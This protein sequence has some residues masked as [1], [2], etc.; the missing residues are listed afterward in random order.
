MRNIM[1]TP[2][3]SAFFGLLLIGC[4]TG[5]ISGGGGDDDDGAAICGNG[6]IEATEG[7]DDGNAASG[8]GCSSTCVTEIAR[9]DVSVDLPS[10][11]T[12]LAS[13]TMLT[14]TVAGA[15]G[16]RGPVTLAATAVD[17]ASA[18]L[19]WT[20]ELSAQSINVAYD[21]A[22]VTVVARVVIPSDGL[23]GTGSVRVTATSTA[24]AGTSTATTTFVVDNRVTI[25]VPAVNGKC[26][27]PSSGAAAAT[28]VKV[29]TKL[30]WVNKGTG[31]II[32]HSNG[33][34]RGIPHQNN[35]ASPIDGVYEK[36]EQSNQGGAGDLITTSAGGA[37]SWYCHSGGDDLG[38]NNPFILVVQ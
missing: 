38:G 9:V 35:T 19:P 1:R 29:G 18:V 33:G 28:R 13:E 8:D 2:I 6:V 12:D 24:G 36:L 26:A 27:Y 17:E 10:V 15:D 20:V 22:P 11:A 7:C 5:D 4:T 34:A 21:S 16:F 30:R 3:L 31:P 23:A 37:F 14:I 25:A 32:I